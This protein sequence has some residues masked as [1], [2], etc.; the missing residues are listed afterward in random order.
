MKAEVEA[1]N[2]KQSAFFLGKKILSE[3]VPTEKELFFSARFCVPASETLADSS[4]F[5]VPSGKWCAEIKR[6]DFFSAVQ[7]LLKKNM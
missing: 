2:A 5:F 4:F 7:K 6:E 1:K 3:K